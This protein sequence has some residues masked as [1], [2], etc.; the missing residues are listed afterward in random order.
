MNKKQWVPGEEENK[1]SNN[2]KLIISKG[3]KCPKTTS[4]RFHN[5][6]RVK[7]YWITDKGF[8]NNDMSNNN[9]CWPD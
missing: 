2:I 6:W 9:V 1:T 4:N 3:M 7:K 5:T 8:Q